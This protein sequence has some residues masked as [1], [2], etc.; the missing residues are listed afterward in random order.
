RVSGYPQT[1]S[2]EI[3]RAY[4]AKNAG[5]GFDASWRKWLHD[6][7]I[8][9][10]G[11][12]NAS[13][14]PTP[15]LRALV[16]GIPAASQGIELIFR[17]DSRLLDGRFANNAWLQEL[18]DPVTKLTWDNAVLVGPKLGEK[19]GITGNL[20]NK[21]ATGTTLADYRKRPMVRVT[22]GG[23]SLEAAAWILP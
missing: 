20:L 9:E 11:A 13:F 2:H 19:L 12:Q 15:A 14:A 1:T 8:A 4:W 17:E 7:V 21:D 5:A 3:V 16:R 22:V 23:T 10:G 6:G 18:P